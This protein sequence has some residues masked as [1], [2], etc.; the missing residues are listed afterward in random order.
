M[1]E[2]PREP[3]LLTPGPLIPTVVQAII[4]VIAELG[5]TS[6]APDRA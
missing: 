1:D 6:C 5:V 2:R 3:S 4:E